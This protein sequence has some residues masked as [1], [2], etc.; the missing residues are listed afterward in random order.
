MSIGAEE[1]IQTFTLKYAGQLEFLCQHWFC[2]PCW[3]N[4]ASASP[5]DQT[6]L[7]M[8]GVETVWVNHETP[9]LKLLVSSHERERERIWNRD[10]VL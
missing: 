8:G 7:R 5:S 9:K 10:N 2:G 6:G 3:H 1:D 4:C